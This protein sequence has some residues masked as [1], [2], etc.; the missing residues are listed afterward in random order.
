M[1]EIKYKTKLMERFLAKIE[2]T[3]D[4]WFWKSWIT[5]EGYGQFSIHDKAYFAHR[6]SYELFKCD[7]PKGLIL[8]HLCRNPSC[9]NPEHLE[10]VTYKINT[11]RGNA[12]LWQ[13]QKTHCPKGHEL[14][15]DNLVNFEIL[16]GWR[17][18]KICH[19]YQTKKYQQKRIK[20]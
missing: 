2:K 15:G 3:N 14:R 6:V 10:A 11:L 16:K 9:V 8:D 12:G 19:A 17:I 7:I 20:K 1:S 5:R 18:C 4:C 13:K